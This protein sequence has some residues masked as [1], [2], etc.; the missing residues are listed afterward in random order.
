MKI[1]NLIRDIKYAYVV[2]DEFD[3]EIARNDGDDPLNPGIVSVEGLDI[4]KIFVP[5]AWS[6]SC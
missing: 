3:N 5:S 4:Q 2:L 1:E 6:N